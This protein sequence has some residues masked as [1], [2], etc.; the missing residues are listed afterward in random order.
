MVLV[1]G[2]DGLVTLS[3]TTVGV[4]GAL[5]RI[6]LVVAWT[7]G[8][9]AA[10]GA[11]ALAVSAWTEHPLV[12]LASVL[13]MVIVFGVL[14]AIPA[15]DWLQPY[16]LTSG[17]TSGADVLRDPLPAHGL[18]ESTLRALCYLALGGGLTAYRMLRRDA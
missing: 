18:V 5:G 8:Q 17:W 6:V 16:L 12:V 14:G 11:V 1:G 15:L 13:G 2:T 4:G 10:I 7:V 3:G 9:L